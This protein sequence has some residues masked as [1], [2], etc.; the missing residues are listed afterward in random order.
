[1]FIMNFNNYKSHFIKTLVTITKKNKRNAII[2]AFF[3]SYPVTT[4][5]N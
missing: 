3:L 2:F 4:I 5:S 1:M